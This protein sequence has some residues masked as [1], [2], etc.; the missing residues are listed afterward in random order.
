MNE[1]SASFCT[2]LCLSTGC[3]L[4]LQEVLGIWRNHFYL[5]LREIARLIY[6][7]SPF[8][9]FPPLL[10]FLSS[11]PPSTPSLL[12]HSC[13]H[14]F[15]SP[16]QDAMMVKTFLRQCCWTSM[17][18]YRRCV[19]SVIVGSCASKKRNCLHESKSAPQIFHKQA[20]GPDK[21]DGSIPS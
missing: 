9:F 12:L 2:Q 14:H 18:E 6:I 1:N 17:T 7:T 8:L 4:G 15:S 16:L 21:L 5:A 11:S 19:H 3:M 10:S 20:G 13:P